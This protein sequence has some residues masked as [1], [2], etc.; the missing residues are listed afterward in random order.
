[1]KALS[2]NH[3]TNR[4]FPAFFFY[5][6]FLK[7]YLFTYSLLVVLGLCCCSGFSPVARSGDYSL[8]AEHGLLLVVGLSCCRAQAP[9]YMGL[10]VAAYGL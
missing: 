2:P 9:G 1:M 6:L 7:F 10:V 8:V 5:S 3:R 4:E